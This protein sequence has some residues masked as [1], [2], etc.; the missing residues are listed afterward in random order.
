[1]LAKV[2]LTAMTMRAAS[3]LAAMILVLPWNPGLVSS[4][5]RGFM[6]MMMPVS[7]SIGC[8]A[9]LSPVTMLPRFWRCWQR[10]IFPASVWMSYSVA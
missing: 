10:M 5:R 4:L 1:M 3:M 8:Q 9:I 2:G 6:A 7:S